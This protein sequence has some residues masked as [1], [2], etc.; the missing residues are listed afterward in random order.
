MDVLRGVSGE[1]LEGSAVYLRG[2]AGR[3]GEAF[4]KRGAASFV[5]H[6][7]SPVETRAFDGIHALCDF[8]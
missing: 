5:E 6:R 1:E 4:L 7:P 8:G 3:V 2:F